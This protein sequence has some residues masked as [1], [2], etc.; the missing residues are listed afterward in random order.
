MAIDHVTIKVKD[1]AKAQAFYAAALKP[2]GYAVLAEHAGMFVGL[3]EGGKPDLW[4]AKYEQTLPPAHV[5]I[6]AKSAA[7]V[8]AFH[9]AAL[10]AGGKDNGAPGKRAEYHAGYYGAFVYDPEGNNLEAVLHNHK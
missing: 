10:A 9:K 3:G 5:A 6:A 4:L 2:L 1:L 8:D 7:D